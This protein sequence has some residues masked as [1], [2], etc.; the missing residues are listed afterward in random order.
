MMSRFAQA[1]RA[2][3]SAIVSGNTDKLSRV[4]DACGIAADARYSY[5]AFADI[6]ADKRI[7]AVY[8]VLPTGLHVDWTVRAFAAGKCVLC[9]KP[10]ALSSAECARRI[11]AGHRANRKLMI[12]YCSHFERHNQE[13]MALMARRAIGQSGCCGPSSPTA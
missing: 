8:I 3:V 5:D 4:G 9:E 13:A 7:D 10:M 2:R 11:A 6:A 1:E 12:A